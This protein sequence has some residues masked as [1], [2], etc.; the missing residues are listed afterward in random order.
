MSIYKI[1]PKCKISHDKNGIFCSRSCANSRTWSEIDKQKKSVSAKQSSKV[2]NALKKTQSK[3]RMTRVAISCMFCKKEIYV[4]ES[5]K[6]S[7]KICGSKECKIQQSINAGRK[8][9]KASATKRCKRS[10]KEIELYELISLHFKHIEHNKQIA[11]GWDADILLYDYK[12]AILWNGPWH[13]REMGFSNH[14]LKQVVNRDC[15]KIEEFENI[16][17]NVLV[18][19]DDKWSPLTAFIDI[20]LH[21]N[22]RSGR[23]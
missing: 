12:I 5:R 2:K 19:Q 7:N 23:I 15:I 18:Y 9:G 8:G 13:Y 16:G 1:C 4:I 10:K 3:L 21:C 17:W 14:S 11:N 20:L 6:D 22:G